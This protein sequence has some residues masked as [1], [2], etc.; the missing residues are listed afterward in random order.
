MKKIVL[1]C[2]SITEDIESH[3]T[4]NTPDLSRAKTDLSVALTQLMSTAKAHATEPSRESRMNINIAITVLSQTVARLVNAITTV[5]DI[6][7]EDEGI[8]HTDDI[9]EEYVSQDIY[10]PL[11]ET[12]ATK[13]K[14]AQQLKV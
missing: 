8:N 5:E 7:V 12:Q 4:R 3:E 1:S 2:K 10:S 14:N 11:P 9:M 6:V 13:P